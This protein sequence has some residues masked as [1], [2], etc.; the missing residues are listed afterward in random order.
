MLII[1]VVGPRSVHTNGDLLQK[2]VTDRMWNTKF[3]ASYNSCTMRYR[4]LLKY[5]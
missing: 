4:K 2:L 3:N 1:K 5:T